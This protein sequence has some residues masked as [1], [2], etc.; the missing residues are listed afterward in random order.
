MDIP[1]HSYSTIN[2]YYLN[3][4]SGNSSSKPRPGDGGSTYLKNEN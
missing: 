3:D 1:Y 4:K 2:R